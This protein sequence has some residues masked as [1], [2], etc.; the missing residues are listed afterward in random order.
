MPQGAYWEGVAVKVVDQWKCGAQRIGVLSGLSGAH[1]ARR[2][3][4]P[5]NAHAQ[6]GGDRKM[7]QSCDPELS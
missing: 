5:R 4:S 6:D 7:G 3:Y 1:K 2:L